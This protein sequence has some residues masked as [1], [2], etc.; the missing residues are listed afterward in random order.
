MSNQLSKA[1]SL[2][3]RQHQ[4]N[5]VHWYEWGE[6]ALAAAQSANKPLLVSIG[7]S[8]CHWCHV[9]AR[10]CFEDDYIANLMN[11]H[12][13]CIK[14]DREERPDI[15]QVYMEAV[16]ML[17]QQGGWPLN[18]F[19]FPDGRP[20]FG[21]TYFPPKDRGNGMIPW[22]QL[23][24]RIA[25]YYK[26]QRS[27]L[28]EN[29]TAIQKNIEAN[30]TGQEAQEEAGW[31]PS[32]LLTAA[33][34]ICG[35]HDKRYGGFGKAPKFPQAMSLNFLISLR[36]SKAVE[37][38]PTFAREIDEVVQLNL[39]AI[40]HG[41]I[42]DQIGG[43]FARYSIDD[44]WLIPH[45]EKM[46]YDNALLITT[47]L[48]AWLRYRNPLFKAVVEET[49]TWLDREMRNGTGGYC[50]A[51]DA[52]SDGGEGKF[53]TWTPDEVNAVLG[54]ANAKLFC[55]AYNLT[56]SGNFE[57]GRSNPALTAAD[58]A[59]RERL[60]P[61]RAKLLKARMARVKPERDA[62][63]VTT[64]NALAAASLA[65]AGF[66][67]M[68]EGWLLRSKDILDFIWEQASNQSLI[69]LKLK[70][71][72]Y[73]EGG[74][75]VEG[76]LH[77]YATFGDACLTFAAY[78]ECAK[79]NSAAVYLE[80]ATACGDA[81]LDNFFDEQN[82]GC[83]LTATGFDTPVARRKDWYD[84]ATPSGNSS[85]L[86]LFHGLYALKGEARYKALIHRTLP[87]FSSY[88]SRVAIGVGHALSAATEIAMGSVVVKFGCKAPIDALREALS[89][90]PYRR[91]F[92]LPA[93]SEDSVPAG[94]FQVCIGSQC[95]R[96]TE[97]IQELVDTISG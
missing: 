41:G 16:Q 63:Q 57:H 36:N 74:A 4:D 9:M 78:A 61:L 39:R 97:S 90:R 81:I 85:L 84:N 28:E 73:P 33:K 62:K 65:E 30:S 3:L 34:G 26:R 15:D 17:Q 35:N 19:C 58:F 5:P 67:G 11:Q 89:N 42:F 48:R 32:I 24:M 14:V 70:A 69:N 37:S 51:L 80:R 10:E 6:A 77:D 18:V 46:L 95:L 45:F 79:P 44:Y 49:I 25:D 7:Y 92:L 20:F 12:F 27:E 71:V 75:Q 50:A 40:A 23:L 55:Q 31:D 13:V 68:H 8:A 60:K 86:H 94:H 38:D 83:F 88:A 1:A 47:Y 93:K 72:Y 87:A 91:T 22:P 76:Y 96:S 43:G 2:Y 64:W 52:D 54:A 59:H 56:E 53:Y 21:G 29:A 66:Y 82:P